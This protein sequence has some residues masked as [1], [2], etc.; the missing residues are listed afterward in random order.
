MGVAVV[1]SL[2][3]HLFIVLLGVRQPALWVLAET[4]VLAL[5]QWVLVIAYVTVVRVLPLVAVQG[6]VRHLPDRLVVA[7]PLP[8]GASLLAASAPLFVQALV[9]PLAP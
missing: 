4:V 5:R 3:P 2:L 6:Q 1:A 7:L 8:W 9:V